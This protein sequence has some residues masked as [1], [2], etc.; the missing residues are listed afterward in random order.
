MTAGGVGARSHAERG[1]DNR[2]EALFSKSRCNYLASP[3]IQSKCS[4]GF[5]ILSSVD[6]VR[7]SSLATWGKP[8]RENAHHGL[9]LI[10]EGVLPSL[11]TR[12]VNESR[13][14]AG[15]PPRGER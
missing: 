7:F 11:G 12:A 4:R 6:S 10:T 5:L 8:D 15:M 2:D 9:K 14:G 13:V 3:W 1:K